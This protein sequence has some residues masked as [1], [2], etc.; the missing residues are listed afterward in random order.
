VGPLKEDLGRYVVTKDE[1]DKKAFKTP[2]LRN[3]TLTPPY[4]HNGA[5]KTLEEV[6]DFYNKGGGDD[7]NQSDKIFKLNLTDREK[8]DL[9]AFL[10]SLTG[11]LPIVSY[12]QLPQV[13]TMTKK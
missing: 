3:V 9:I 6:V 7:P 12:P 8:E 13:A 1:K 5:F 10:K 4:T 2:T 11:N